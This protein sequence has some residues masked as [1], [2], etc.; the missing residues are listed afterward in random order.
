MEKNRPFDGASRRRLL[1][2]AA[3]T[4]ALAGLAACAGAGEALPS[5]PAAVLAPR[6]A[7]PG[8]D[9]DVREYGALGDGVTDDTAAIQAALDAAARGGGTVRIPPGRYSTR[10]LTLDTR[11]H[12]V[13]SGIESTVLTLRPDTNADLIRS[14]GLTDLSGSNRNVGPYNF[15]IRDLTLDGNR[16]GNVRGCGLRLYAFGYLLSDLRIRQCAEAGVRSEWST[17]DPEWS[18]DGMAT[19]GDSME[20]Q[21]VNLKV[22]HCNQGGIH[23]RG[24]H[25]SQFVN[26][27]VYDT[28]TN[29]IHVEQGERFSATGCQ[30][31]N[32]HVWG[33]HAYAWKIESGFVT[34][35]NCVGEWARLAQIHVNADDTS[36]FAGRFFGQSKRHHVGIEIG[37]AGTPVYGSQIDAR[38]SDLTGGAFK[39]S[40]EGG[41]SKLK[42]LVYQKSGAAYTGTPARGSLLELTVN[43]IDEGSA[44]VF[45]RGS[46]AW[47]G[48]APIVRHLSGTSTW[49]PGNVAH[50]AIAAT[51]VAVA[52]ASV[53]D[54]V[55]VGF[56]RAVPAGAILTGA[57]TAPGTVTITLLNQSGRAIRFASGTLRADC[58]VH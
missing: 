49:I 16:A 8:G 13:G 36:I 22:H 54:T 3:G 38:M 6:P 41:S 11:V 58:W 4:H 29:G 7:S 20:A 5:A 51:S 19:P 30:F 27:V 48:G 25:D 50:G 56:S 21:V 10:T 43:G 12:L 40:G 18:A 23:F 28:A 44:T 55:A 32:C 57:V 1:A 52:G 17:E 33:S 9:R 46:L 15:S 31:V 2:W 24:P 42:A 37:T 14:R 34:L 26:C 47:N 53:G 39:F 45:P 35:V